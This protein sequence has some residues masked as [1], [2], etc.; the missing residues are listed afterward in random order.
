MKQQP[1]YSNTTPVRGVNLPWLHGDP[2]Q[3][4]LTGSALG[5]SDKPG[6]PGG[7]GPLFYPYTGGPIWDRLALDMHQ[8]GIEVTP[9]QAAC[10]FDISLERMIS[11]MGIPK[12][13]LEDYL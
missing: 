7:P 3:A 12:S 4:E 13:I 6:L 2:D 1:Q 9:A 11:Q 5:A 8:C 10:R